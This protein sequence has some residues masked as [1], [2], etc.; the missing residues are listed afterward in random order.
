[1]TPWNVDMQ[2]IERNTM[3]KSDLWDLEAKL[4]E[5][6]G[7]FFYRLISDLEYA[8]ATAE[9]KIDGSKKSN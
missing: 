3:N 1:M 4:H 6:I 9:E 8:E 5:F 7:E 2:G